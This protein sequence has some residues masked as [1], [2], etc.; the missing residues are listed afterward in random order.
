MHTRLLGKGDVLKI[1]ADD[2]FHFP[3]GV[4]RSLQ[5]WIQ[6]NWAVNPEGPI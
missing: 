4:D 3:Q 5:L 6:A 1:G 2:V